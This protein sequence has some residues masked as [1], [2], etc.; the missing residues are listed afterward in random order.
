VSSGKPSQCAYPGA[1]ATTEDNPQVEAADDVDDDEVVVAA[2]A[3]A[4]VIVDILAFFKI[5]DS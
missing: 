1:D 3:A 2:A 5:P 4:A